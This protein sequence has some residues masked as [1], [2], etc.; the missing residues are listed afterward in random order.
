MKESGAN[1]DFPKMITAIY[2]SRAFRTL[3]NTARS[4]LSADRSKAQYACVYFD[5]AISYQYIPYVSM[6]KKDLS[7]LAKSPGS[8]VNLTQAPVDGIFD[9]RID[10]SLNGHIKID[11]KM[12]QHTGLSRT[13]FPISII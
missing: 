2:V 7:N 1:I 12:L 13:T 11:D 5:R 8:G 4:C 10:L 3:S 6:G 9:Y